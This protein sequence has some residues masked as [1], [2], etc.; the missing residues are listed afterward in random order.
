MA[1]E[2]LKDK[3]KKVVFWTLGGVFLYLIISFFLLSD[4][5]LYIYH[6]DHKK[7]Y[8]VIKDALTIAAAF[9]AP[10]AAFIL[11]TDWRYQHSAIKIENTS[12]AIHKELNELLNILL[13]STKILRKD[14]FN[15]DLLERELDLQVKQFNN[16]SSYSYILDKKRDDKAINSYMNKFEE[17]NNKLLDLNKK[18]RDISS[19]YHYMR[20]ETD[21]EVLK[22]MKENVRNKILNDLNEIRNELLDIHFIDIF[23]LYQKSKSFN[24]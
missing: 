22:S 15:E 17:L 19:H 11:F 4:Y 23:Q 21:D 7:S 13:N 8:E 1:Q 5:P 14:I 10:V 3:I 20:H 16:L 18:F 6:F 2:D 24:L 9:L 12:E